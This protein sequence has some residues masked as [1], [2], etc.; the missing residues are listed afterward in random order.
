MLSGGNKIKRAVEKKVSA[1]HSREKSG[2]DKKTRVQSVHAATPRRRG[3]LDNCIATYT[4]SQLI[5]GPACQPGAK[6]KKWPRSSTSAS[7]ASFKQLPRRRRSPGYRSESQVAPAGYDLCA[8]ASYLLKSLS[9]RSP[10]LKMSV[11]TK[12]GKGSLLGLDLEPQPW[13]EN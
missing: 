11:P 13:L 4:R 8:T 7:I 2:D 5:S 1:S 10:I 12:M 6:L 3:Q 9:R